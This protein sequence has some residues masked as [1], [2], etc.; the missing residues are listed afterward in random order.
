MLVESPCRHQKSPLYHPPAVTVGG[1]FIMTRTCVTATGLS[2]YKLDVI[3]SLPG[4]P[5]L[6]W[7]MPRTLAESRGFLYCNIDERRVQESAASFT[8]LPPSVAALFQKAR[9]ERMP[10]YMWRHLLLDARPLGRDLDLVLHRTLTH[11]LSVLGQEQR[12]RVCPW[13]RRHR[14]QGSV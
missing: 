4:W 13:P 11:P 8:T 7:S 9:G 12:R 1:R 6:S 10:Q 5:A 3:I 14:D 2:N